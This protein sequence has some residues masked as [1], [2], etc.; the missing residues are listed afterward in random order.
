MQISNI[1][2]EW[3]LKG[4]YY[5]VDSIAPTLVEIKSLQITT[6]RNSQC[7]EFAKEKVF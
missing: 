3:N 7:Q 2:G 4:S 5:I 1:T 6:P